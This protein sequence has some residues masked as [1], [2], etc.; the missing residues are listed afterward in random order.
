MALFRLKATILDLFTG[1]FQQAEWK[2]LL[3]HFTHLQPAW[4]PPCT[5]PVLAWEHSVSLHLD[6]VLHRAFPRS[7]QADKRCEEGPA[8]LPPDARLVANHFFNVPVKPVH[9]Y[10]KKWALKK[11]HLCTMVFISSHSRAQARHS[12]RVAVWHEK[13]WLEG[14][15]TQTRANS[16]HAPGVLLRAQREGPWASARLHRDLCHGLEHWGDSLPLLIFWS[17][18]SKLFWVAKLSMSSLALAFSVSH[19]A[20][21]ENEGTRCFVLTITPRNWDGL[22]ED[23]KKKTHATGWVVIKQLEDINAT[24]K[25]QKQD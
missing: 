10:K 17:C 9:T 21:G 12:K 6:P 13:H 7:Y 3:Y 4:G 24:L 25:R 14:M 20:P 5:R 8:D 15:G 2:R 22:K 18:Q 16:F 11:P 19:H 23:K 1:D